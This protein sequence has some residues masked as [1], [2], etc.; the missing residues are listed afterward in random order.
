MQSRRISRLARVGNHKVRLSV[1]M[2]F[3]R[4]LCS[5]FQFSISAPEVSIQG[6]KKLIPHNIHSGHPQ[7]PTT[8]SSAEISR[9]PQT[10]ISR[11]TPRSQQEH[12]TMRNSSRISLRSVESL[13]LPKALP[14]PR[15]SSTPTW[16]IPRSP[17]VD[18]MEKFVE[19]PI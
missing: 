11:S 17:L 8:N 2:A 6:K 15:K 9:S 4:E 10:P 16:P 12:P 5:S 14:S 13:G 19:T 1:P 7:R 3:F 18:V